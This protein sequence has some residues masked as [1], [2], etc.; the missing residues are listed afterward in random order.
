M[1]TEAFFKLE[2]GKKNILLE[3]A[4]K[5]FSAL[6]YEKVSVFKIA[7]NA[8]V[9]RSG[10]YY[11]F[12]DKE[13]IY[14]YLLDQIKEE[15]IQ[16]LDKGGKQYDIF[17]FCR[18]VFELLAAIKG[19]DREAFFKQVF[20]NLKPDDTE[21]FFERIETCTAEKHFKYLCDLDNLSISSKQE[22]LGLSC[23]LVSSTLYTLQRY[24]VAE[25]PLAVAGEK[26]DQMFKIIKYGVLK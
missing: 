23:L 19:T 4:V 12:K 17:S 11:Y 20:S 16:E 9:S 3:S 18:K 1:P 13:D 10:F 24:L 22:L 25:E 15:F 14:K 6:P 8:E 2:E 21:E 26:L 7:Q 5:E